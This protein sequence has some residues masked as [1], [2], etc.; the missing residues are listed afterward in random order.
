MISVLIDD[1]KIIWC[2]RGGTG[3]SRLIPC[4]EKLLND[5]KA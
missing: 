4:L 5:K 3:A 1:S 2:I